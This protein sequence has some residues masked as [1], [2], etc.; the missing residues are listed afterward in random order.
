MSIRVDAD[1]IVGAAANDRI[2]PSFRYREFQSA[3]VGDA[4]RPGG[5][6][7]HTLLYG[8]GRLVN[9]SALAG[10][11]LRERARV[12]LP[13]KLLDLLLLDLLAH[14]ANT[15]KATPARTT[16]QVRAETRV[17]GGRCTEQLCVGS[18]VRR[19]SSW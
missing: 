3:G 4:P 13:V 1:F 16:H 10:H 12:Q 7:A 15:R 17:I 9:V 5:S 18:R 2:S 6:R 14:P 8:D 19:T 11:L